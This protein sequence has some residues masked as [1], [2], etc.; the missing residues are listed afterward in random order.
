MK[1]NDYTWY[2]LANAIV[3]V[4]AKYQKDRIKIEQAYSIW[5]IKVDGDGWMSRHQINSVDK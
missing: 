3:H 5:K 1:Q 4:Q 2:V